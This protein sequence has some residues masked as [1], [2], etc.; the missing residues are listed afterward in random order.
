MSS[1]INSSNNDRIEVVSDAFRNDS[2]ST[3]EDVR[4]VGKARP[5]LEAMDYSPKTFRPSVEKS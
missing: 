4:G 1:N 5:N 2:F 3:K